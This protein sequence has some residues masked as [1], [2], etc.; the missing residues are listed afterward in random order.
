MKSTQQQPPQNTDHVLI[1]RCQAQK[2][3]K[4]ID[5]KHH[6]DDPKQRVVASKVEEREISE[7]Y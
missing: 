7:P 3:N 6:A 5:S 1:R 2:E 4:Q